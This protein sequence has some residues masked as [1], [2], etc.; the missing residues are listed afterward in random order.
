M[1]YRLTPLRQ[2]GTIILLLAIFL[3]PRIGIDILG[4]FVSP[5]LNNV[6]PVL[7]GL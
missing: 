4:W 6:L 5:V 7:T 1:A 3:L 2:Y